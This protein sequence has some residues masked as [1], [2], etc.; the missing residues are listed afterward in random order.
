MLLHP[1][2]AKTIDHNVMFNKRNECFCL[3]LFQFQLQEGHLRLREMDRNLLSESKSTDK[4]IYRKN[5]SVQQSAL[6]YM[7]F[8]GCVQGWFC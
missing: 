8:D 3:K 7:Q 1:N 2:H 6:N 4:T 5:N